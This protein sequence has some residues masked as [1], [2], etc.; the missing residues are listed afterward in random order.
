MI[1]RFCRRLSLQTFKATAPPEW[2][3]KWQHT[4]KTSSSST[5][6]TVVDRHEK[7]ILLRDELRQCTS[8]ARHLMQRLQEELDG[9]PVRP[10]QMLDELRFAFE[11]VDRG[12]WA[13]FEV[14]VG[15]PPGTTQ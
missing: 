11:S 12:L 8:F 2:G 1:Y 6:A 14:H 10:G 9:G 7:L 4:R 3:N 5:W 15:T 13:K